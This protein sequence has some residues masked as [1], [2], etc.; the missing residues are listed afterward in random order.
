M[1]LKNMSGLNNKEMIMGNWRRY[2]SIVQ[3]I[4]NA[5]QETNTELF[6][7]ATKF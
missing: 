6:L 7:P 1:I 5:L 2:L 4:L 3:E